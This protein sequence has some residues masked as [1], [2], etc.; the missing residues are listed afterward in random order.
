MHS[1]RLSAKRVKQIKRKRKMKEQSKTGEIPF[2]KGAVL[3]ALGVVYG[4]IG[5]SPMY[6]MKSILAENG[7]ISSASEELI[8]GSLSLII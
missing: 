2:S 6:V 7:G 3:V 1:D 4:D 8:L 5:T